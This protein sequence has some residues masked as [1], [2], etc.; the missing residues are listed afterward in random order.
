MIENSEAGCVTADF[1]AAGHKK[2]LRQRH[3][4]GAM[5]GS[6]G[7]VPCLSLE[8]ANAHLPSLVYK[9]LPNGA[10]QEAGEKFLRCWDREVEGRG[11]EC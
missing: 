11:G 3:R 1:P 7:R 8:G 2:E 10:A 5:R 4:Q 9:Q 6:R